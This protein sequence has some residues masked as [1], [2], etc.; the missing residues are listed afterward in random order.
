VAGKL[1][2]GDAEKIA[3][4]KTGRTESK[5]EDAEEAENEARAEGTGK[6]RM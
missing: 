3:E 6:F 1:R 2:R 5:P 4:R